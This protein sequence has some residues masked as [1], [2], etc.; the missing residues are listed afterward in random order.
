[1]FIFIFLAVAASF[2]FNKKNEERRALEEKNIISNNASLKQ[3]Q[4]ENSNLTDRRL[5]EYFKMASI[6]DLEVCE[7]RE[8]VYDCKTSIARINN[9]RN[10]CHSENNE[11]I[12]SQ[13]L[14]MMIKMNSYPELKKC[15]VFEDDKYFN[16]LLN[17]FVVYAKD[18]C[19]SLL[20]EYSKAECNDVFNY[21]E[22]YQ[23]YDMNLCSQISSEKIK[24]Y[25]FAK[26]LPLSQVRVGK[27][28]LAENE[29]F[30]ID[31]DKDGLSDSDEIAIYKTYPNNP[32]TDGDGY[33][34]GEEVKNGFNP[35]GLGKLIQ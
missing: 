24:K 9:N 31:A 33:S 11:E 12:E 7:N 32:D 15:E 27:K 13:C 10:Y 30:A 5:V 29:E 2:F 26:I 20:D 28:S 14:K 4:A 21:L 22:I 3:L 17:V 35:L 25:C 16:C 8:D 1:M 6:N 23:K 19:P 34:D 18:D